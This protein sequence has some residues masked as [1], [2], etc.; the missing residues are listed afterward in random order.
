MATIQER[1]EDEPSFDQFL[2]VIGLTDRQRQRI[3]QDGFHT[4]RSLVEHYKVPGPKQFETYL[5]DLNKTFATASTVALRIYFSPG[6]INRLVGCLNYFRHLVYTFHSIADLD[7]I[8]MDTANIFADLWIENESGWRKSSDGKED[9][10]IE[11]P[12]LKGQFNWV[13]FRDAFMYKLRVMKSPKGCSMEYL[14]DETEREV[15]RPNAR[16]I[17]LD[18]LLDLKDSN[19]FKEKAVH[20]GDSFKT[21]NI[22]LWNLVEAQVMNTDPYNHIASCAR[23]KNGIQAWNLL[24]LQ[25]EGENAKQ[26]IRTLAMDRLKSTKYYGDTKYF[27]FEKYIN[28]HVKAHKQLLD[29]KYNDGKGLDNETMIFYFKE[30]IE[31]K[32]DLETALT[33]GRTRESGTFS[34]YVIFMSTEVDSKNRRKKQTSRTEKKVSQIRKSNNNQGNQNNQNKRQIFA[35]TNDPRNR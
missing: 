22:K 32:A 11:I 23:T 35:W 3:I 21:D 5:K 13:A 20:F 33:L 4:M 34:D 24:K 14:L 16:L 2:T 9:E 19:V 25:Y 18:D 10:D 1:F 31:P 28:V 30:G 15:T 6:V 17:E 12:K 26:R 7:S 8:D 29:I 27:N